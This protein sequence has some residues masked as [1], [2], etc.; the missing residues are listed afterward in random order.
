MAQKVTKYGVLISSP[1]DVHQERVAVRNIISR[2]NLEH[3]ATKNVILEALM[4]ETHAQP[5]MDL[6]AQQ[7][8]NQNLLKRADLLI[9]ILW[10]RMGTP[11]DKFGSGTEEEIRVFHGSKHVYFSS[12]E[13]VLGRGQ[14]PVDFSNQVEKVREF[15]KALEK[16]G[17]VGT[18]S[19]VEDLEQKVSL[20]LTQ[21]VNEQP[22][23]SDPINIVSFEKDIGQESLLDHWN[24]CNKPGCV[25]LF[26]VELNSFRD[27][28]WFHRIWG[29][30]HEQESITQVIL[31]LPKYKIDRLAQLIAKYKKEFLHH[32]AHSKFFVGELKKSIDGAQTKMSTAAAFAMFRFG[33]DPRIG[34]LHPRSNMYIFSKP[35]SNPSEEDTWAYKY[36]LETNDH[37]IFFS[38]LEEIWNDY[39]D[40]EKVKKVDDLVND[41]RPATIQAKER[42][43][44]PIP[45]TEHP[46]LDDPFE[47]TLRIREKLFHPNVPS[48]TLSQY[49]HLLD[50]NPAFELTFPTHR[51]YRGQFVTEFLKCLE[52]Y[53][54]SLDEG[55]TIVSDPPLYHVE[56]FNYVSPVY[57]KMK[58]TKM[59][60]PVMEDTGE[61]TGWNLALNVDSVD[62]AALYAE[63]RRQATELDALITKYAGAYD[64][65]TSNF[66]AYQE[67]VQLHSQAVADAT[68][69]L[70]IGAGSGVLTEKLLQDGKRVTAVDNNDQ[71]LLLLRRRCRIPAYAKTLTINKVNVE[72]LNGLQPVFDGAVLL[73]VLFTLA[74]PQNCLRKIYALLAPGSVLALAGPRKTASLEMLFGEIERDVKRHPK[75]SAEEAA[76]IS[77]RNVFRD[78]NLRF[79]DMGMINRYDT[80]ETIRML[81]EAGFKVEDYKDGVYAGQSVFFIARKPQQFT[82]HS[83]FIPNIHQ[84]AMEV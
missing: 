4:W 32:P 64:R 21:W 60:S 23:R 5:T 19:S 39:F 7:A 25:L 27:D 58:F 63:H 43:V 67:L 62:N 35:F 50:W 72:V 40:P 11:T 14:D 1:G 54:N 38:S 52:N 75:G 83:V 31:L 22:S 66:S 2:W 55:K 8:I 84:S 47:T 48:Y 17:L 26:N 46:A 41:V 80:D 30:V 65:I 51:F 33:N 37:P 74:R 10:S 12:Q 18:F 6:K 28:Y 59:T 56:T 71:M 20:A 13:P 61:I 53:E 15:K 73:H 34:P 3:S 45:P 42:Q 24:R 78:V 36:V 82:N 69:V 44:E 77:H 57:G 29:R 70:D 16:E 76:W 79:R 81:T 9:A 68:S 49:Y